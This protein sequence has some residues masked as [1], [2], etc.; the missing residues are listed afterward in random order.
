M[1]KPVVI[2]NKNYITPSKNYPDSVQISLKDIFDSI[3]ETQEWD[4][5]QDED[6]IAQ[7]KTYI[8]SSNSPRFASLI[9]QICLK[10]IFKNIE[11]WDESLQ[12]DVLKIANKILKRISD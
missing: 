2:I 12:Q 7:L 5:M 6:V 10:T 1:K 11:D 4:E 3:I 9:A 8:T